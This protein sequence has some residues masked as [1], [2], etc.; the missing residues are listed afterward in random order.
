MININHMTRTVMGDDAVM[1][2]CLNTLVK[3]VELPKD[4]KEH[5]LRAFC[6]WVLNRRGPTTFTLATILT[7]KNQVSG[8]LE[9]WPMYDEQVKKAVVTDGNWQL[10]VDFDAP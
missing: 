2:T 1:T 7:V 3:L 8:A 9:L 4:M 5:Q 10:L 6:L